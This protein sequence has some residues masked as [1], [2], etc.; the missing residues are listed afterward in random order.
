[1]PQA[2]VTSGIQRTV[3]VTRR[4][5]LNCLPAPDLGG[6]SSPRLHGM[7][8]VR[9]SNPLSSTTN[10]QG[11]LGTR[12]PQPGRQP[13]QTQFG[14]LAAQHRAPPGDL[15]ASPISERSERRYPQVRACSR[16]LLCSITRSRSDRRYGPRADY[17]VAGAWAARAC[18]IA[19]V[20]IGR[21]APLGSPPYTAGRVARRGTRLPR[22]RTV[23]R[24]VPG[25]LCAAT[26]RRAHAWR[27]G[28]S[29]PGL[30]TQKAAGA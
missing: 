13:R 5:S 22:A 3:T 11:K 25:V 15:N 12:Q 28:T 10:D 17:P 29:A 18:G 7:Q 2:A 14:R 24:F 4:G 26:T 1:V 8:G 21:P 20:R 9:G 27:L 6:R 19:V 30:S 16:A 23:P